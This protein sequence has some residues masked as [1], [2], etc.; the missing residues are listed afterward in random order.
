M[1][2]SQWGDLLLIKKGNMTKRA[3]RGLTHEG[4]DQKGC[5][6]IA[7]RKKKHKDAEARDGYTRGKERDQ[8]APLRHFETRRYPEEN[9]KTWPGGPS[10]ERVRPVSPARLRGEGGVTQTDNYLGKFKKRTQEGIRHNALISRKPD[11][12][13]W[14]RKTAG[15]L[16]P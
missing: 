8:N 16:R 2:I 4:G 12:V 6:W 5:S 13:N 10:C 9:C 11:G 3:R 1:R 7:A 15:G 14:S